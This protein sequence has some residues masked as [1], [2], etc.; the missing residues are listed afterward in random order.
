MR[1]GSRF[2]FDV[3]GTVWRM[4]RRRTSALAKA[5]FPAILIGGYFLSAAI[6]GYVEESRIASLEEAKRQCVQRLAGDAALDLREHEA[7]LICEHQQ[8]AQMG[9][10]FTDEQPG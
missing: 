9:D 7:V 5:A 4:A 10:S 3:A 1:T 6:L 2:S 8:N